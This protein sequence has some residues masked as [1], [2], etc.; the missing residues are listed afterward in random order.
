MPTS[1]GEVL[2]YGNLEQGEH[3]IELHAL[4]SAGNEAVE[5]VTI[6]VGAPN[7]AP[8]CAITAP[9]DG[10]TGEEGELVTFRGTV[11]DVDVAADWLAVS[12]T[13]DKDGA[14]GSS[15]PDSAGNVLLAFADLSVHP[16]VVTMQVVDEV[17]ATCSALLLY[18]V[19]SPPTIVLDAPV[20]GEVVNEGESVAFAATV[21]D[22]EDR[23]ADLVVRWEDDLDGLLSEDAPDSAGAS[24]FYPSDLSVGDHV[25]TV[26]VT[27]SAGLYAREQ[28]RLTVNGVPTAPTVS[29]T[30]DPADT[31]GD[32]SA[33]IDVA[34]VDPD[35]DPLTYT[36]T[37]SLNGVVSGA[38]T[39]STV[40]AASTARGDT[41]SIA[42]VASD[43]YG[44]SPAGTA[45]VVIANTAPSLAALSLTPDPAYEGDTLSCTAGA[46][47]DADGDA[48]GLTYDCAV[49]GSPLGY[50][51]ATLEASAFD[52]GDT[53]TCSA[54]PSD[55]TDD[56]ATRTSTTVTIENSEPVVSSVTGGVV[57][58]RGPNDVT[59]AAASPMSCN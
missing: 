5:S 24:E 7:S 36:Y 16:H 53:V 28:V 14:F 40:P 52:R 56:G 11:G 37:W 21:A 31:D 22:G 2:G 12:W 54:T 34:A 57:D 51:S 9:A 35:G 26:T 25:L 43:G 59:R 1:S 42:I 20:D 55:G 39:T 49:S 41:W 27:D 47:T 6:E 10:A 30:P 32:L 46:T 44:D 29:I 45:S 4:D 3:A 58:G 13:S 38:S 19:G 23:P 15:T 33:G 8:T 18:T 48:V 17:G 50:D